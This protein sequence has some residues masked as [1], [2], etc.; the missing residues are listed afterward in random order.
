MARL[1][2]K[3]VKLASSHIIT[4]CATVAAMLLFV[5][6]GSQ[7]LPVAATGRSLPYSSSVLRVAFILNI[8]IILFGWRRARDLREALD[9]YEAAESAAHRNANTDPITG[10]CNRRELM[11]II[12]EAVEA[13]ES[14]VLLLLDLDHFKRVNDLH[15]HFV[16]DELLRSVA[17]R[18]TGFAPPDSCCARIGGDEFALLMTDVSESKAQAIAESVL[19]SLRTPLE[20]DNV[21]AHASGSIGLAPIQRCS[22]GELLMRH[23]DVALYGAKKAGRN[24]FAWFDAKTERELAHRLRQEEEFRR[25]LENGEFVPFFQP[26]I[27]LETRE[28]VGFEALARWNSP[29]GL[30]EA[31][32]FIEVAER[33]GLISPLTF[34]ILEQS[35]QEARNWPHRLKLAINISPVQFRDL[36]L[37]EQIAKLLTQT[38]FPAGRLEVEITEGSLLEDRDQVIATITSLKN[39]GMSIS[40][41]DFGTG[42]A[43]LAQ[44]RSLPIDRIKIDKSF[45][46]TMVKSDQTAAIVGTIA[47]LGHSLQ[48]PLTAEGVE[49]EQIR[50]ALKEVGCSEAQ[51]WLFGRAVSGDAVRAFLSRKKESNAPS[52]AAD[53][54][55]DKEDSRPVLKATGRRGLKW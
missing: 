54:A 14:G 27:D 23:A 39:L 10:L 8:A 38:G 33:T 47:S 36:R 31:E 9:A 49:S 13:R 19:E 43:S 18:L 50:E 51:G 12:A 26:L 17:E 20:V 34:S 1:K 4:S 11:R 53:F 45:I 15:G 22:S 37:A 29:R 48:V 24:G 52:G 35:L 7:L 41:D 5:G 3:A 40:L 6:L 46:N 32:E 16:G 28:V 44:V 25:A 42:Y 2:N 55:S 21:Q 30:L